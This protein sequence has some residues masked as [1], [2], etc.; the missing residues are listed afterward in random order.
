[1]MSYNDEPV[2]ALLAWVAEYYMNELRLS[3]SEKDNLSKISLGDNLL[4]FHTTIIYRGHFSML[5]RM[6][7]IWTIS[8]K[9]SN[10]DLSGVGEERM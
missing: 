7:P 2:T 8:L 1:M 10:Q 6:V 3:D 5:Q 9:I 4:M